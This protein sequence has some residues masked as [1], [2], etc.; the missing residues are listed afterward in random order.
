MTGLWL[1]QLISWL[2]PIG[3]VHSKKNPKFFLQRS[4]WQ[5]SSTSSQR[6]PDMS[7]LAMIKNE[8]QLGP[9]LLSSVQRQ[10]QLPFYT[11]SIYSE[12]RNELSV[13]I[14]LKYSWIPLLILP[15]SLYMGKVTW[16]LIIFPFTFHLESYTCT[17][18][19]FS[20]HQNINLP[21]MISFLRHPY[22]GFD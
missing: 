11:V 19:I 22:C 6:G 18:L 21:N 10:Q 13:F 12:T 2:L 14:F 7:K 8:L 9:P 20:L 17:Y 15:F 16:P 3:W 1:G 4:T 5:A